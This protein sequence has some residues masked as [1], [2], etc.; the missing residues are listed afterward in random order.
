[1]GIRRIRVEVED[2]RGNRYTFSITRPIGREKITQFIELVEMMSGPLEAGVLPE[3]TSA[4]KSKF[5][6]IMEVIREKYP[7]NWFTSSEIQ[8]AYEEKFRE[9]ISLSTVSTYL[10]RYFDKGLLVREGPPNMFR[11]RLKAGPFLE[12]VKS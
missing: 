5:E 6:K 7:L 4:S 1:M 11:Y 2:D 10:S 8:L 3:S 12:G 9:P